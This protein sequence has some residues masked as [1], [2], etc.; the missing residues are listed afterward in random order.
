[1]RRFALVAL[2]APAAA[3]LR[4]APAPP[5]KRALTILHTTDVH[6]SL[7]PWDDLAEPRRFARAREGRHA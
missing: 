6:G 5:R 2:A 1:M 3:R 7:L 4:R